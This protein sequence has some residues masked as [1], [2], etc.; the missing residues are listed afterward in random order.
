MNYKLPYKDMSTLFLNIFKLFFV[1]AFAPF[2][3]LAEREGQGS[4]VHGCQ[5]HQSQMQLHQ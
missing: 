3:N 5:V 2:F 4:G 1:G